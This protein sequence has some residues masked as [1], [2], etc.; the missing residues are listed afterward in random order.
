MEYADRQS[1]QQLPGEEMSKLA[2][3]QTSPT[4]LEREETFEQGNSHA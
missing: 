3:V 1:N 4:L 2:I